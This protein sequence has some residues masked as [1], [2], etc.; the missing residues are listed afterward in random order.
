MKEEEKKEFCEIL[1]N[2]VDYMKI[3]DISNILCGKKIEKGEYLEVEDR[4]YEFELE[5]DSANYG[6]LKL[7][8]KSKGLFFK[9]GNTTMVYGKWQK[10][11]FTIENL[12]KLTKDELLVIYRDFD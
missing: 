11:I 5:E 9:D 2:K 1:M 8:I 10:F 12:M 3:T 7:F 6:K 4:Q